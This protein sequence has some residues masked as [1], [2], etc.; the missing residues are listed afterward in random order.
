[1]TSHGSTA[2]PSLI[3]P[4]PPL[5]RT[6]ARVWATPLRKSRSAYARAYALPSRS[7][8]VFSQ[9]GTHPATPSTACGA[10]LPGQVLGRGVGQLALGLQQRGIAPRAAHTPDVETEGDQGDEQ[11]VPALG[12]IALATELLA[13][14]PR[15]RGHDQ[16]VRHHP[17][18]GQQMRLQL[19]PRL[20]QL[21]PGPDRQADR[22]DEDDLAGERPAG[23]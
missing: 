17:G 5:W 22:H 4:P 9:R 19:G 7:G 20:A 10:R 18:A 8:Y 13:A 2:L 14:G 12:H 21:V 1:M 3:S 11:D 23:P 16:Q 15:H 6:R